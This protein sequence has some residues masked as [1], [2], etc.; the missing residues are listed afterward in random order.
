MIRKSLSGART[1]VNA[2]G[3]EVSSRGLGEES[4]EAGAGKDT[5]SGRGT[6]ADGSTRNRWREIWNKFEERDVDRHVILFGR[7]TV[8][9][10]PF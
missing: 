10:H 9:Q 6:D 2:F 7:G 1:G 8:H 4:G 5:D 3:T